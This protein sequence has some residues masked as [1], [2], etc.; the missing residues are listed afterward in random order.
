MADL[1]IDYL[2]REGPSR[3]SV[4]A[5][6]LQV[7]GLSPEAAR[8]RLSRAKRPVYKFP[9]RL[10]PKNE[11]F[12][13]LEDQRNRE[14]FWTNFLRDLRETGSVFALA[15]DGMLARDSVV[16]FDQFPVISGAPAKPM[17]RQ[18]S[19]DH[20][21]DTLKKAGFIEEYVGIDGR[22]LLGYRGGNPYNT[23]RP[24]A[25][26]ILLDALREWARKLGFASYNTIA[27]RGEDTLRPIG[28]FMFDLA[29]P[30]WFAPVQRPGGKPGFLVADV[31]DDGTLT[32]YQIRFFLRKVTML[33]SMQNGYNIMPILVAERFTAAALTAG[34]AAGISL[35][36]PTTLFGRRVGAAIVSLVDTLK[37]VAAYA[38]A[39]SPERIVGLI[40]DLSEIE[41]R[42]GNLRGVLFELLAAYLARR[43]A[44]SIDMGVRARDPETGNCADID[45][46][47]VTHQ[48]VSVTCIECKGKEPGGRV[49]LEDVK[50]WLR[51]TAIMRAH[52]LAHAS[53]R[54]SEHRFELWTSGKFDEDALAH[55]IDEKAKRTRAPIGWKDGPA[56][57]A[58]A[59]SGKDKAMA[60]A[61]QEHFLKHPLAEIAIDAAPLNGAKFLASISN[62]VNKEGPI[63]GFSFS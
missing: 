30:S 24:T 22:R 34:H 35:A 27:I 6:A 15:I 23:P 60:D 48:S 29:G 45:V 59:N 51:K 13:Y 18:L 41:G 43:D 53:F 5:A 36:T 50:M 7:G 52:L 31:F 57:L 4:L 46:L 3:G 40:N 17:K 11:A 44:V 9:L 39:Q 33:R 47:K 8:Q 42:N 25:E 38:S 63:T 61:F 49:R 54:E 62:E 10:L 16:E 56:V 21:R 37:N 1:I 19:A 14:S 55:L 28:P 32:E 12:Y 2:R 20:V 26:L 58:L